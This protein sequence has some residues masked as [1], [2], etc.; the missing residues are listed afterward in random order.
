MLTHL[1]AVLA[2]DFEILAAGGNQQALRQQARESVGFVHRKAGDVD[3]YFLSN[4]SRDAY[5][6]RVRFNVGHKAPERWHPE[7]G[8]IEDSLVFEHVELPEGKFTEVEIPLEPF[9]SCFI[10]FGSSG[11]PILTRTNFPGALQIERTGRKVR[12]QGV[13]AKAGEYFVA[14]SRGKRHRFATRDVPEPIL[15]NNPWQLTLG[16]KPAIPLDRLQSWTELVEGKDYSGWGTYET[17]FEIPDL[18]NSLEWV[19]DLGIVH[20]TAEVV[21]NGQDLGVAWKAPRRLTC[22]NALRKGPNRLKVEV[23]NLWIQKMHSLPK[24]NLKPLAET[25]GIRWP[26]YGEIEPKEI[27]PSGLLGPVRLLPLKRFELVLGN[28]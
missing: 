10:V 28:L 8:S 23:G 22:T 19:L 9:E 24:P 2:P 3:F 27:P 1:H 11:S 14:D 26:D 25:Y 12:V 7:T 5:N 17:T 4:I 20:E 13:A 16:D 21:L 6:L 18:G 15:L